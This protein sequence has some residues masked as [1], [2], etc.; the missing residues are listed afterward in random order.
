MLVLLVAAGLAATH[1]PVTAQAPTDREVKAAYVYNFGRFVSWPTSA[2]GDQFEICLLGRDPLGAVI[3]RTIRGERLGGRPVTMR[4]VT[5]AA[6]AA[7][8]QV[9]VVSPS[10][11]GDI[12]NH[13]T[14]LGKRPILTVSD[15]PR[16]VARGGMIEFVN[17]GSRVRFLVDPARAE[18]AGLTLSSE[19]LRVAKLVKPPAPGKPEGR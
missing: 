16:F 8:C 11:A 10:A 5:G 12:E 17:E 9:L 13:L 19:L 7:G 18:A 14:R 6:E 4:V 3:A 1:R 2:I 15:I